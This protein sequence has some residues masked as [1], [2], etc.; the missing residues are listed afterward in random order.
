MVVNQIQPVCYLI[1]IYAISK[2]YLRIRGARSDIENT[3]SGVSSGP[4]APR[5][6]QTKEVQ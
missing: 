2:I 4:P 5:I 1:V 6:P 3:P